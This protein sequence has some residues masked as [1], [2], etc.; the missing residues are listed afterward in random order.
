MNGLRISSSREI[1]LVLPPADWTEMLCISVHHCHAL[2][3]KV[4][5]NK[6]LMW[7][8]WS[9]MPSWTRNFG[10]INQC[11]TSISKVWELNG[12]ISPWTTQLANCWEVFPLWESTYAFSSSNLI[13]RNPVLW[14][15]CSVHWFILL[16]IEGR[17]PLKGSHYHWGC[18]YGG[19]R[20]MQM[21]LRTQLFIIWG[22]WLVV[23]HQWTVFFAQTRPVFDASSLLD[24]LK[25]LLL[26]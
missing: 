17:L 4:D 7:C 8:T 20:P 21:Q 2:K 24:A 15:K 14:I 16:D 3:S 26:H 11:Q 1:M 9:P 23:L 25:G 13:S 10:K 6:C 12:L 18:G 5:W 22:Q 19:E